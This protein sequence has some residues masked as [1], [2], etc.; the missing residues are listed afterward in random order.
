MEVIIGVSK[1]AT[2]ILAILLLGNS[3][4][5]HQPFL[6]EVQA[7]NMCW[8]TTRKENKNIAVDII[9]TNKNVNSIVTPC[10]N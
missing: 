3:V 1:D 8:E 2:T 6:A 5:I 7:V 10:W 4:S 9:C